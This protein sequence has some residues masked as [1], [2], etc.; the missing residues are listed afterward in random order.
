MNP[1]I[2][3]HAT[4]PIA[5]RFLN[6]GEILGGEDRIDPTL[7]ESFGDSL[8]CNLGSS[9]WENVCPNFIVWYGHG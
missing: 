8:I 1:L 9:E 3:P 2:R 4:K 5:D 7:F 6:L